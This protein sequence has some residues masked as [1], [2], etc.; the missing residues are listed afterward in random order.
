MGINNAGQV[1]GESSTNIANHAFITGPNGV[2]MTDL[3]TLGG[4]N[5]SAT[6]INSTGEVTGNSDTSKGT[7]HAFITDPNGVEMTDL[8]TLGSTSFASGINDAGQVVGGFL[9]TSG[10]FH[11]FVTGPNGVGMTDLNSLVKLPDGVVLTEAIRIN[12]HG[13]IIATN[14]SLISEPSSHALMLAG[15]GLIGI[16]VRRR[17]DARKTPPSS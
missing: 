5:S 16:L 13:Q 14:I 17:H 15:L 4:V 11:A 9:P 6:G 8:G 3:G 1:A 10:D 7:S 2:G 12:N